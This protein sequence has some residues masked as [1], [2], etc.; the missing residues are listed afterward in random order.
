MTGSISRRELLA[1]IA[2]ATAAAAAATKVRAAAGDAASP[3]RLS[4][5]DPLAVAFAYV[6]DATRVDASRF[7][8]YKP[9]QTCANCAQIEGAADVEWRPCVLFRDKLVK[10]AGWCSAYVR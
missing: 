6:E 8:S 2:V 7:R 1:K 4:P 10:A 5:S 9:G 3:A